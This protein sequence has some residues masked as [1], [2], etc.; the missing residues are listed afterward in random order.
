MGSRLSSMETFL[1]P[2]LT[3]P[4]EKPRTPLCAPVGIFLALVPMRRLAHH[5]HYCGMRR[6]ASMDQQRLPARHA[7]PVRFPGAYLLAGRM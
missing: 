7:L 1:A 6:R 3:C 4:V 2:T 5:N